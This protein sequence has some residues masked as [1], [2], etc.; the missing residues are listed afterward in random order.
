MNDLRGATGIFLFL[1]FAQG[2]CGKLTP[3]QIQALP[4]PASRQV[5]FSQDIKPIFDASCVKCHGRGRSKGGFQIDTRDTVLKGGDSGPAVVAG[6]KARR[7][8]SSNWWP[9]LT[10]TM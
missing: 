1:A 7:A 5:A 3:E 9:E 10:R 2:A 8:C 4:P 6:H